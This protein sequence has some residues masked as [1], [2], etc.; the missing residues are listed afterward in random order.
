[1]TGLGILASP[2]LPPRSEAIEQ[3][4]TLK[5]FPMCWW[6]R[7]CRGRTWNSRSGQPRPAPPPRYG[8]TSVRAAPGRNSYIWPSGSRR[9]RR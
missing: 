9:T 3:I 5:S 1:M 4:F 6:R 2:G 7:N 8:M